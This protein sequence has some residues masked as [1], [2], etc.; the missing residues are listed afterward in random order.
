[1]LFRLFISF[2]VFVLLFVIFYF[3]WFLFLEKNNHSSHN[4]ASNSVAVCGINSGSSDAFIYQHKTRCVLRSKARRRS[5]LE[6]IINN[7]R[8]SAQRGNNKKEGKKPQTPLFSE[9]Q[10]S[11]SALF[12]SNAKCSVACRYVANNRKQN[13]ALFVFQWLE[14]LIVMQENEV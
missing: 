13:F 6:E 5:M 14:N 12:L 3:N 11:Q 7:H 10:D 4:R 1:M 9:R 8:M 2:F